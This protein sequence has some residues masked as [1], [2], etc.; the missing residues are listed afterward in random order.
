MYKKLFLLSY[1]I[2]ITQK[3]QIRIWG[4]MNIH[5]ENSTCIVYLFRINSKQNYP[6]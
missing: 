3:T 2:T 6:I 5:M 1:T 4:P